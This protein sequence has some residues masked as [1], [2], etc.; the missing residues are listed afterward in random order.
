VGASSGW[1]ESRALVAVARTA[2]LLGRRVTSFINI[3]MCRADARYLRR[4]GP[5][6][7]EGWF[8]TG[9]N[10]LMITLYYRLLL[11]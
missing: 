2:R 3:L 8:G 1:L 5:T 11:Q 4:G 6:L 10:S 7:N 9:Q